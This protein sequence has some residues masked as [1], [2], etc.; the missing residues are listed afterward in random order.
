MW[1]W[2][3]PPPVV[4]P[5][6]VPPVVVF[7]SVNDGAAQRSTVTSLIVSFD[8]R[9]NFS[10]GALQLKAATGKVHLLYVESPVQ[11][12]GML[13]IH[14]GGKSLPDGRYTLTVKGG[15][16]TD[17]AT[18]AGLA[19]DYTFTFTRLFG[20]LTGDGVYDRDARTLVRGAL[21]AVA[22]DP[23][24]SAALDV[25]MDGVIDATDELAAVRNW[26]KSV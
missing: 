18:G 17:A 13:N 21:G 1:K 3:A 9:I 5:D 24:Y 2:D 11:G 14:F 25:N 26:G 20:D 16:V 8:R 4:T 7:T 15:R 22:G 10:D 12:Q 19:A 6:P 23:G